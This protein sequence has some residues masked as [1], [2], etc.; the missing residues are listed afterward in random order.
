MRTAFRLRLRAVLQA[1]AR[2]WAFIPL[3]PGSAS[4]V[5]GIIPAAHDI[6]AAE[7]LFI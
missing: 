7:P 4:E 3:S 6:S 5:S 1:G 2:L